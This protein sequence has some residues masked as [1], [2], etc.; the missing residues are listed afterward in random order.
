MRAFST[1]ALST[2]HAHL[3]GRQVIGLVE[4]VVSTCKQGTK[5]SNFKALSLS[6]TAAGD[7]F[8]LQRHILAGL[9]GLLPF[10]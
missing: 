2:C 7:L 5:A 4:I 8:R 6:G 3:V 10:R 1:K 9:D